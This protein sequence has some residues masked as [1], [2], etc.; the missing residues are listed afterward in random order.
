MRT[1]SALATI[2]A[3]GLALGASG[4]ATHPPVARTVPFARAAPAAGPSRWRLAP[5]IPWAGVGAAAPRGPDCSET[6]A[7][8]AGPLVA[9]P[10]LLW[11]DRGRD[12]D[13]CAVSAR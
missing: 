9:G 7:G 2:V 13:G 4:A 5:P 1:A 8:C 11:L 10:R 6:E 12:V 3:T